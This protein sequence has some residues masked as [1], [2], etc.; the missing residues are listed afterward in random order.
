MSVNPVA[1]ESFKKEATRH[2]RTVRIW[3]K[4]GFKVSNKMMSTVITSTLF[5]FYIFYKSFGY[6]V[7]LNR[8]REKF[9]P[10][11]GA[12]CNVLYIHLCIL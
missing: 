6:G 8:L 10:S 9:D 3:V 5:M 2:I 4:Q 11:M 1:I 7:R 12:P